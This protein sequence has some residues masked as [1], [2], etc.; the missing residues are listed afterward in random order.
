MGVLE[1][2]LLRKVSKPVVTSRGA[3]RCDSPRNIPVAIRGCYCFHNPTLFINTVTSRVLNTV[4]GSLTLIRYNDAA[5]TY[6]ALLTPH[7]PFVFPSFRYSVIQLLDNLHMD[8][9]NAEKPLRVPVLD[10]YNDRGT[11]VLGKVE[12]VSGRSVPNQVSTSCDRSEVGRAFCPC[13][14]SCCDKPASSTYPFLFRV[15]LSRYLK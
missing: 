8:D 11:M 13:G 3:V 6:E 12:Q 2:D 5:V 7:T 15:L 1:E 10:R 14:G 4:L 9:R